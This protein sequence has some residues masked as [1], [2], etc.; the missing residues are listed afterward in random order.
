MTKVL[1]RQDKSTKKESSRVVVNKIFTIIM[2]QRRAWTRTRVIRVNL[3][4]SSDYISK[5]RKNN[6]ID[7]VKY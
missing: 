7:Y 5:S 4:K 1:E 3:Q 2:T 6:C